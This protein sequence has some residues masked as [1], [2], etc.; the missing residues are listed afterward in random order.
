MLLVWDTPLEMYEIYVPVKLP[1]IIP[2]YPSTDTIDD[3]LSLAVWWLYM[4][5]LQERD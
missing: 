1:A 5:A 3:D 2:T 4:R